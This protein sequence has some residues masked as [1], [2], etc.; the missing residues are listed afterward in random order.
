MKKII[1]E[2]DALQY[3]IDLTHSLLRN[4]NTPSLI[5]DHEEALERY[6]EKMEKLE[7]KLDE[8][9]GDD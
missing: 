6:Y 1:Q 9:G 7:K 8:E 3:A 5:R 2:I 4:S